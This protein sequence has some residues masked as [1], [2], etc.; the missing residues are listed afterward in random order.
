VNYKLHENEPFLFLNE[1]GDPS[2]HLVTMNE[3]LL[4]RKADYILLTSQSSRGNTFV[5]NHCVGHIEFSGGA[6]ADI[7]PEFSRDFD[8]DPNKNL[9]VMLYTIFGI[10]LKHGSET[11]N[12]FEFFVRLFTSEINKLLQKGLRSAYIRQQGNEPV[13]KG[14]ILFAE[15]LRE[16][17]IHKERI[18]CEYEVFTSNRPENR[19]IKSTIEILL[20]QTKDNNNKKLLKTLLMSLEEVPASVDIA[21]DFATVNL[22]RNMQDYVSP[23]V[24]CSLFLNS[25]GLSRG[26]KSGLSYALLMDSNKVFEAYVAKSSISNRKDGSYSL[27]YKAWVETN[28][29]PNGDAVIVVDPN[30]SFFDRGKDEMITDAEYLYLTCPGYSIIPPMRDSRGHRISRIR[31]IAQDYLTHVE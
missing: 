6:S 27:R 28:A 22:D 25:M 29:V 7:Y 13:L 4:K 17:L 23:L 31:S 24:W 8:G 19:L 26:S 21:N 5:L 20:K 30:W 11:S 1:E 14:R 18:F 15:N 3:L 16:N 9:M 12:L 2:P 10:E